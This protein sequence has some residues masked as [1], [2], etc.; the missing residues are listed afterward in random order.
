[1]KTPVANGVARIDW[2][3]RQ[4]EWAATGY[5]GQSI[6]LFPTQMAAAKAIGGGFPDALR[7]ALMAEDA[8]AR[9]KPVTVG[10]PARFRQGPMGGSMAEAVVLKSVPALPAPEPEAA[11]GGGRRCA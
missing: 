8:A 7:A 10:V 5:D 11:M 6:G 9:V 3:P 2:V 1:M 4:Q